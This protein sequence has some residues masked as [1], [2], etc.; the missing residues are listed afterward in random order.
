[1]SCIFCDILADTIP[2]KKIYEDEHC[3]AFHD[4][5][6]RA[7]IHFLI[8]PKEHIVSCGEI[9]PENSA[10]VAHIFTKIP[11]IVKDLGGSDFRVVSNSGAQ[12]GQSVFHLHFHVL[13]GRELGWP[14]G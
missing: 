4:I 2:C 3:L 11:Q 9:T 14:P 5:D 6:G 12:A 13:S 10:V 1:M 7:P 8:I